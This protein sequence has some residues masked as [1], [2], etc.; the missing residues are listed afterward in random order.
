MASPKRGMIVRNLLA[1]QAR[2][3]FAGL[4]AHISQSTELI[5]R[6]GELAICQGSAGGLV[7]HFA[8]AD[9]PQ[10]W[11]PMEM[12]VSLARAGGPTGTAGCDNAC[13]AASTE[14]K[15]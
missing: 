12:S 10:S 5:E 3:P 7:G 8:C 1:M 11:L 4:A 2:L 15:I 14:G 13:N 6:L 9:D